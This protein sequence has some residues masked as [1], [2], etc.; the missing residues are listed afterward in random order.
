MIARAS[1]EK[2]RPTTMSSS[3]VG[4]RP[5]NRKASLP[6][7]RRSAPLHRETSDLAAAAGRLVDRVGDRLAWEDAE[8]LRL[9]LDLEARLANAFVVAV[10]GMRRVGISDREI[11]RA[12][13]ITR[14]AVEQ[15]W[16]RS[17]RV[18]DD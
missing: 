9:L 17:G 7:E 4:Q 6:P 2:R 5:A 16:P 15:R 11:G 1:A 12:L 13:G 3:T 10:A 14:Q 8:D 18:G